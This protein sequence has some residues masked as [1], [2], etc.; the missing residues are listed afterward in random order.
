MTVSYTQLDVYKRQLLRK[1]IV[2]QPIP[3]ATGQ[4]DWLAG[5]SLMMRQTVLD[6]IGLFDETFFLY[7][8][9]TDLCRRA[10]LAEWPTDYVLSL[11]HI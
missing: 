3:Q 4:V 2:A 6:Q 7:F 8:E 10:S 9:E 11:I 1:S 5:A